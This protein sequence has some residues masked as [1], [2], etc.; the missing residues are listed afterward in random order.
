MTQS[1]HCG[2]FLAYMIQISGSWNHACPNTRNNGTAVSGI[3]R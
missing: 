1:G 3:S 2:S